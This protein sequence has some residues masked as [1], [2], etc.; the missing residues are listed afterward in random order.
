MTFS[1]I[2][3]LAFFLSIILGNIIITNIKLSNESDESRKIAR[4][5]NEKI[6]RLNKE[7]K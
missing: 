6:D 2:Q 4:K 5:I 3:I 1:D 7:M